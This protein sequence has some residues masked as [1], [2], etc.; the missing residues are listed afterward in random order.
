MPGRGMVEFGN[1]KKWK[2]YIVVDKIGIWVDIRN[3]RHAPGNVKRL[4]P[5]REVTNE[6]LVLQTIL[7]FKNA[8]PQW[9]GVRLLAGHNISSVGS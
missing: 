8:S 5:P 9:G 4:F 7:S 2:N 6:A 3:V 1:G